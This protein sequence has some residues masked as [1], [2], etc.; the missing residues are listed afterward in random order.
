MTAVE[1]TENKGEETENASM[2]LQQ[3]RKRTH[4]KIKR[5]KQEICTQIQQAMRKGAIRIQI[6]PPA[7][8]KQSDTTQPKQNLNTARLYVPSRKRSTKRKNMEEGSEER[9]KQ[10]G[11][12]SHPSNNTGN[13]SSRQENKEAS[14]PKKINYNNKRQNE[15]QHNRKRGSGN[16]TQKQDAVQTTH[17]TLTPRTSTPEEREQ[18]NN[19]NT[20]D[21]T[22]TI[23]TAEGSY[24]AKL[25]GVTQTI[26]P[27]RNK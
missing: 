4:A 11:Q 21:K 7:E 5:R 9:K 25:V 22:V 16:D 24:K 8:E 1:H 15:I 26:F 19:G 12:T 23:Q 10:E 20:T 14:H 17:K 2:E 27:S 3:K 18:N 6:I 13:E